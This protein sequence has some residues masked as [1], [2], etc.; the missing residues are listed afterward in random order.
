[1][2][3]LANNGLRFTNF[4]TTA[5]CSPTRASLLTGRNPHSAHMG[6]FPETAIDYP[7]YDARIPFEKAFIS[8]VLRENGYNTF[9][10]G[11][12][13]VTPV[14]E[15]TQAGPFNRWP[16]GRGFDKYFGFLYGETDQYTPYLVEGTDHY[17]GDTKGKH[18][19][20]LI[21]DKA[22]NYISNQKSTNPDKPFFLYYAAGAGHAPHQ[23]DKVWL[24]KYKGKF[25][26]GWDK[27]REEVLAN[28]KRLG[29]VPQN[30]EIPEPTSGIK[31]WD[32]LSTDQKKVY[33]RFQEA[34]AAFLEH[35]DY[36]LGRLISHLKSINQFDNTVF[37]V[38]VGDNG[39]SKEGTQTGVHT[40]YINAF[41]EK[42]R[43]ALLL[44]DIDNIGTSKSIANFPLG[45]AQATNTPF[46]YL[47]QDANAEGGT[48]NPLIIHWPNGIKDKGSIRNQFTHVNSIYPTT[49]ELTGAKIPAIINGYPQ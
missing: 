3:A 1:L 40:G 30:V 27:Y 20:T 29:L 11:K 46:R 33:A 25:D 44:K 38:I 8:E 43:I 15:V 2:E 42:D 5:I 6:L 16:T 47:K 37:I 41:P 28:Q 22:I 31:R 17:Q 36:E 34:Y 13:H 21:T 39:S 14:N 35:T 48:H 49:L 7:G 9:A 24:D 4:H 18:F 26:K 45:W 12:W 23:V 10:V 32:S 19:T